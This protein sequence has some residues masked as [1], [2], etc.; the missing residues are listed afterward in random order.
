[1]Y[2]WARKRMRIGPPGRLH[3]LR[4]YA[5]GLAQRIMRILFYLNAISSALPTTSAFPEQT[6]PNYT[7]RND[8]RANPQ[9]H[10]TPA[11][12]HLYTNLTVLLQYTLGPS[13]PP[14]WTAR[15][16][17]ETLQ[18]TF[19]L[20]HAAPTLT[21]IMKIYWGALKAFLQE[22]P[23]HQ[24]HENG[25]L[26]RT[27]TTRVLRSLR[28]TPQ[29][30]FR[31]QS[32]PRATEQV[33]RTLV[34]SFIV[35]LATMKDRT[36]KLMLSIPERGLRYEKLTTEQEDQLTDQLILSCKGT[37]HQCLNAV[38]VTVHQH[39][40]QEV[41]LQELQEL[42]LG[43][44]T[45]YADLSNLTIS[46]FVQY[47]P[48]IEPDWLA[49]NSVSPYV[50]ISQSEVEQMASS[51]DGIANSLRAIPLEDSDNAVTRTKRAIDA[52]LDLDEALLNHT[53]ME[54]INLTL[55][56]SKADTAKNQI[57]ERC[58]QIVNELAQEISTIQA[59]IQKTVEDLEDT[60]SAVCQPQLL[61]EIGNLTNTMTDTIDYLSHVNHRAKR[62]KKA[63]I[64][65][66]LAA[67]G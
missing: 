65:L 50:A 66:I 38:N 49:I 52:D 60:P 45:I 36:G 12:P 42:P 21:L 61:Q 19:I 10:V 40:L 16:A 29:N 35:H 23:P 44:N 24:E 56:L 22:H 9:S 37:V 18:I 14:D 64:A 58:F 57:R 55:A 30:E 20:G 46:D 53:E 27:R 31:Y 11:D 17:T 33:P 51:W 47:R 28:H 15:I 3:W 62:S 7:Y 63:I 32:W 54:R 26:R 41:T 8:E 67:I 2:Q 48:F 34:A 5:R 43:S 13:I 39:V 1:M 25:K 4:P 59:T 6:K